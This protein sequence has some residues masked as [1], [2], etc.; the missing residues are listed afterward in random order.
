MYIYFINIILIASF[1]YYF[2]KK[3]YSY[4]VLIWNFYII[5]LIIFVGLRHE[6]GGDWK[7]YIDFFEE[8][9]FFDLEHISLNTDIVYIYINKI[10]NLLGVGIYGVNLFSAIIFFLAINSFLK[11]T[12][13]KWLG[14]LI[15]F[16][17]VIVVLGM[18]Y[19]RQGLAFA[20]ALFLIL[21]LENRKIIASLIYFALALFSHK[22][23]LCCMLF[24]IFYILYY[25][26]YKFLI[27]CF[28]GF[29]LLYFLFQATFNHLLF[30]YLGSGQHMMS[31]GSIPR[32]LLI[33]LVSII[34]LF[35]INDLELSDYQKF[36]YKYLSY[37]ILLIS[38]FSFL[39][40]IT[41]DRILLYYCMIKIIFVSTADLE[42]RSQKLLIN[43][44]ILLYITYFTIWISIGVN[45]FSWLP[46]S[47]FGL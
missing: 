21:S 39:T 44:I 46:Y 17:I 24:Y 42:N 31:F 29:I 45:S 12:K 38:P 27:L 33:A 23:S 14:L 36:F 10:A 26:N 25:K 47:I 35:N 43:G 30:F 5:F 1:H 4:E 7:I 2:S 28:I 32:S 3:N 41:T 37:I 15:C 20:F 18:G 16:P 6:V 8:S 40:S 13:N 34:F 22:S 9:K 19:A 11:N